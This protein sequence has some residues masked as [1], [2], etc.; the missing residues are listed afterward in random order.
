LKET[1]SVPN[2]G[3]AGEVNVMAEMVGAVLVRDGT[4][5]LGLRSPA[6]RLCPN[7]WD[8]IGGHVEPG[9]TVEE[10]LRRELEE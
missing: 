2:R 7:C 8:T 10:T 6:R 9:E 1:G 3:L 5:L 4:L